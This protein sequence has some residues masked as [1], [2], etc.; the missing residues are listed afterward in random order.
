M[1]INK[2]K[3]ELNSKN[4]VEIEFYSDE[5]HITEVSIYT[6]EKDFQCSL[7][8]NVY[9]DFLPLENDSKVHDIL[10]SINPSITKIFAFTPDMTTISENDID[11]N[12]FK[13]LKRFYPTTGVSELYCRYIIPATDLTNINIDDLDVYI[14]N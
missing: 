5:T 13:V 11:E 9:E 10:K 3:K 6:N 2:I 8:D 4:V 14:Q 1:K 12:G 7:Y